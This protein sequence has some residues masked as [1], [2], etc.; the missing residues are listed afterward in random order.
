MVK[1]FI[2]W[3]INNCKNLIILDIVLHIQSDYSFKINKAL[4]CLNNRACSFLIV[5]LTRISQPKNSNVDN[6]IPLVLKPSPKLSILAGHDN[7]TM[8]AAIIRI[9]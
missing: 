4:N 2:I 5:Q 6:N 3:I 9:L 8:L 7:N 1:I